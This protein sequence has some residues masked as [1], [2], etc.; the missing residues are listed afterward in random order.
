M[1]SKQGLKIYVS[2]GS[3]IFESQ[4]A[5]FL[6][7][8]KTLSSASLC[9]VPSLP[10]QFLLAKTSRQLSSTELSLLIRLMTSTEL[11]YDGHDAN[12]IVIV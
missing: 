9:F 7:F 6:F 1:G 4:K 8:I 12:H 2:V 10:G 11:D 3:C 5:I